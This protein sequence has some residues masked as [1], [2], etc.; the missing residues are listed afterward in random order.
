MEKD[1]LLIWASLRVEEAEDFEAV[2]KGKTLGVRH[3]DLTA[4]L[5]GTFS[6]L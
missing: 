2:V 1:G 3:S 4:F 6:E 5:G